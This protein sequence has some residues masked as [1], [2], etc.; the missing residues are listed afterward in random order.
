MR[1]SVPN[2]DPIERSNVYAK[3]SHFKILIPITEGENTTRCKQTSGR[4][5]ASKMRRIVLVL[6]L[7]FVLALIS[8]AAHAGPRWERSD[9]G[10]R[11]ERADA[12]PRWER[13]DGPRWE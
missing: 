12:G 2:F 1:E 9:A 6:V 4:E 10:P 3:N 8:Q 5:G 7:L 11:W 13:A